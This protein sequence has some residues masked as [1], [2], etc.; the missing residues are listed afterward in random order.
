MFRHV[1]RAG[2]RSR[3]QTLQRETNI[4]N[5]Q[6]EPPNRTHRITDVRA[7]HQRLAN[8]DPIIFPLL[9]P[10]TGTKRSIALDPRSKLL[11]PGYPREMETHIRREH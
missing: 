11:E 2:L 8:H 1:N 6:V 9:R 3:G 5:T 4:D 7:F 10:L